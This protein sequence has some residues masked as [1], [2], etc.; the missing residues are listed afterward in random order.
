MPGPMRIKKRPTV[1]Q[2]EAFELATH[3]VY[4]SIVLYMLS[5]ANEQ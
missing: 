2:I 5:D 1:L 4:F 3:F